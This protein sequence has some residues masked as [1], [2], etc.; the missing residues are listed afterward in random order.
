MRRVR[1]VLKRL[2]GGR[3][4]PTGPLTTA[5]DAA[6]TELRHEAPVQDEKGRDRATDEGDSGSRS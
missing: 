2:Q 6:A 1:A 4:P 5:E 3:R